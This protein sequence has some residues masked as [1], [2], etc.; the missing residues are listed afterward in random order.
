VQLLEDLAKNASTLDLLAI[1]MMPR[2]VTTHWNSTYNMLV[3]ALEY[4]RATDEISGDKKMRKYELEAKEWD[5]VQQL[6]DVL[7]VCP[8]LVFSFLSTIFSQLFKD[9]TLF[10][11]WSTPNLA[12]VI[13]A[14]DHIDAHLATASQNLKFSPAI[15]ASLALGKTHLNKY[16]DMTDHSE[17][18]QIAMSEFLI[19]LS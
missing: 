1:H 3:F 4:R 5:L 11:S 12:T 15:R 14:M 9:A 2:D 10:F 7:E 17:V 8:S 18:Y 6:C 19:H 16:Y 13:P